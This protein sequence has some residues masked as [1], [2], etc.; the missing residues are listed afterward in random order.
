MTLTMTNDISDGGIYHIV[1]YGSYTAY[2][3]ALPQ[4]YW[5]VYSSEQRIKH[6]C[7][8]I[9]KI[10]NYADSLGVQLNVTHDD[11][12]KLQEDFEKFKESGFNE[13]YEKQI[14]QWIQDNATTLFEKLAKM[15]FFGLTDDGHFCAYIPDS[16]SDIT[17][18][19]GA[20]YGQADYGRL[21]LRF[22]ADGTGVINNTKFTTVENYNTLD[23]RVT[24]NEKKITA[25][26]VK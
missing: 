4:F 11:V 17:F 7:Y 3:P 15:V 8:E 13:Y 21:I 19:T 24:N 22:D 20:V 26:E 2:T 6:I 12:A 23:A 18:D 1:P 16:W 14:E 9:D 10:I 5:D 25:L